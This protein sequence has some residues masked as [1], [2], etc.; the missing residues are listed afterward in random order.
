MISFT[1]LATFLRVQKL[2]E[3]PQGGGPGLPFLPPPPPPPSL[4]SHTLSVDVM[5]RGRRGGHFPEKENNTGSDIPG[6]G[7]AGT[8][9]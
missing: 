3:E 7:G 6:D 2:S 9:S 5:R 8:C 1:S 4:I